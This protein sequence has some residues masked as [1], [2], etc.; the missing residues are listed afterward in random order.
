LYG[1]AQDFPYNL[2]PLLLDRELRLPKGVQRKAVTIR[3]AFKQL[4][5]ALEAAHSTGEWILAEHGDSDS[6]STS[7][8]RAT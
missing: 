5:Q 4:L 8:Y 3:L 7:H 2:E 1:N 6:A